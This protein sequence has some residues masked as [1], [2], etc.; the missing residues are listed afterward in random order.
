MRSVAVRAYGRPS[1]RL[2]RAGGIAIAVGSSS[3]RP[4][5]SSTGRFPGGALTGT[6][7]SCPKGAGSAARPAS[8]RPFRR[9]SAAPSRTSRPACRDPPWRVPRRSQ[10]ARSNDQCLFDRP[11]PRN[12]GTSVR[13]GRTVTDLTAFTGLT[14]FRAETIA[15]R[16]Q[17]AEYKRH[18]R[19]IGFEGGFCATLVP[20]ARKSLILNGEMSEWLKEHAWKSTPASGIERYRNISSRNRFNDF[21]PQNPSR[22]EPVS[23]AVCQG[24]RGDLTQFLHN[25][26]RHFSAYSTVCVGVP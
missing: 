14:Q 17:N 1:V 22:C 12:C 21:P 25:S 3:C 19:T 5:E 26:G 9:A 11:L 15:A 20:A 13:R 23:V 6:M 10:K 7:P 8:A 24:F 16:P 18:V 4:A 2:F